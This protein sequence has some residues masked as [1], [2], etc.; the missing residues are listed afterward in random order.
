MGS[1]D[2][3][4]QCKNHCPLRKM[5]RK[6]KP[7]MTQRQK[8]SGRQPR[9]DKG[10]PQL[11]PRDR[12]ILLIV[13][14][15]IT[16]R[17]D[18]FQGLLARHPTTSSADPTFLS[19]TRTLAVIRRW[20]QL[21]LAHYRKILND[22]LGWI[23]LSAK[24]LAQCHLPFRFHEPD[25]TSLDHLFW[26]N[27]TRALVEDSYGSLPEFQWESER[28]FRNASSPGGKRSRICGFHW[29]IKVL[30]ARMPCFAIVRSMSQK[31]WK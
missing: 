1:S 4:E 27:E 7:D 10:K 11:T 28:R 23:W 18:Q 2:R 14:E 26:I 20:Q 12:D 13:G 5:Q 25:Y 16:Y 3:T 19:E 15:Q 31:L 21:S 8:P 30:I 29:N 17:F 6:G 24:G 9:S 22:Q